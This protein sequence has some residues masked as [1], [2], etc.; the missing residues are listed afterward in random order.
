MPE[1]DG[2]FGP[3]SIPDY[4]PPGGIDRDVG[5][6]GALMGWAAALQLEFERL[7]DRP[8]PA[9]LKFV[10]YGALNEEYDRASGLGVILYCD[11]AEQESGAVGAVSVGDARFPI[12]VRRVSNETPQSSPGLNGATPTCWAKSNRPGVGEGF[13]TA[14]HV[15]G[16]SPRSGMKVPLDGG[17]YAKLVDLA[18]ECFDVA[19]L[20]HTIDTANPMNTSWNVALTQTIEVDG[21]ITGISPGVVTAVADPAGSW[22]TTRPLSALSLKFLVSFTG[23]PGDSGAL[24]HAPTYGPGDGLGIYLGTFTYTAGNQ[25]FSEGYCQHLEQVRQLMDLE[26]YLF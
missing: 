8:L 9:Y 26:L 10:A 3:I 7:Q 22:A 4:D 18:P 12:V 19:L 23:Q 16:R 20:S 14:K 25:T 17:G 5:N 13:L 6:V 2:P 21:H 15:L 1:F 11:D 24:V